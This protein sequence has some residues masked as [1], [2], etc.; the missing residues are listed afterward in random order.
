MVKLIKSLF[1]FVLILASFSCSGKQSNK[2]VD[3]IGLLVRLFEQDISIEING[4]IAKIEYCPDNTCESFSAKKEALNKLADFT[5]LYLFFISDHI[6]LQD[7]KKTENGNI[8]AI[9]R[10]YS[11][12]C[13][14]DSTK[15]M[16]K[17]VMGYLMRQYTVRVTFVRYDEKTRNE[18]PV[19]IKKVLDRW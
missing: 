4:N 8:S 12:Q 18:V 16:A 7:F 15:Q 11:K 9:L 10:Q 2:I 19:D 3:T 13:V 17:C 14:Q 6:A 1:I 5:Y